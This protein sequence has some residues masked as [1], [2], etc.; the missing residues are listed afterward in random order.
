MQQLSAD[1]FF[2]QK[3]LL[4]KPSRWKYQAHTGTTV[5]CTV[6][7]ESQGAEQHADK[8]QG[9]IPLEHGEHTKPHLLNDPL[10]W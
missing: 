5:T 1:R 8:Q 6:Q 4:V 2:D 3:F 10:L 9:M 7:K